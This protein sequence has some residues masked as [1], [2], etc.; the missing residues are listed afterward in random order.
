[1][2]KYIIF[3]SGVLINFALNSLLTILR[4]LKKGFDGEFL[5]TPAVKYEIIDHPLKVQRFEWGALRLQ[6]LLKDGVIKEATKEI[7]KASELKKEATKILR[8]SNDVFFIS[9][10]PIHLL[11]EGEAE[12]LALSKILTG[13]N[14][15]NVIA[16]DERT[17]RVLCESPENLKEILDKKLHTNV[18]V[19]KENLDLFRGF[20]II[21]STELAYLAYK[22]GFIYIKDKKAIGAITYALKFGGCSISEKEA[23]AYKRMS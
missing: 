14:K 9:K 1:M 3:D 12:C 21:R 11:D 4:S 18:N 8:T 23:E 22:K 17:A 15:E 6:K 5:I 16:I 2:A 13:K 10:K 19:N 7:V 20:D